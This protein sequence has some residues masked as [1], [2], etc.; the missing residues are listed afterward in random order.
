M[1]FG[2]CNCVTDPSSLSQLCSGGAGFISAMVGAMV[3]G[4][5]TGEAR[6]IGRKVPEVDKLAVRMVT[7]NVVIQFVPAETRGSLT[8]ERRSGSNTTHDT[9][10]RTALNGEWG[11]AMHVE[12]QRGGET[13]HVLVDF[14]YT[15]EVL[16]NN[17]AIDHQR[18]QVEAVGVRR[19]RLRLAVEIA[20][21]GVERGLVVRLVAQR[22]GRH[23]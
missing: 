3:A 5:R 2:P 16:N 4:A 20:L 10:P 23:L 17:M 9:Q 15:P 1:L 12:S 14:G 22:A 13:R 6:P 21:D 19:A 11:L 18:E 8:I 7:D